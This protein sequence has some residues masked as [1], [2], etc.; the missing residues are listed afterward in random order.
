VSRGKGFVPTFIWEHRK[1]EGSSGVRYQWPLVALHPRGVGAARTFTVSM[2]LRQQ[3]PNNAFC[4]TYKI[5]MSVP[6]EAMSEGRAFYVVPSGS[7]RVAGGRVG[8]FARRPAERWCSP[9]R[10]SSPHRTCW[11]LSRTST[12]WTPLPHCWRQGSPL[13]SGPD[14]QKR[15]IRSTVWVLAEA[16]SNNTLDQSIL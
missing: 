10:S 3:Q 14:C 12:C 7:V 15:A 9:G 5:A 8:E 4:R 13:C 11:T 2:P 6:S 16:L 1:K